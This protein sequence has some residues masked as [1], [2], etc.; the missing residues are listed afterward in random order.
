MSLGSNLSILNFARTGS[1]LSVDLRV[2]FGEAA[3]A[4]S[5]ARIGSCSY[6]FGDAQVYGAL[7]VYGRVQ[8]GS[9]LSAT[10]AVSLGDTL[11]VILLARITSTVFLPWFPPRRIAFDFSWIFRAFL[12]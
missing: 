5:V 12:L 2:N 8:F 10:S 6:T 3:P 11:S 1:E 7:S 4:R 9:S